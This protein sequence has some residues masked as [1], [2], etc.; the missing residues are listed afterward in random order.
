MRAM[1]VTRH[2]A[3]TVEPVELDIPVP[4][5]SEILVRVSACGVCR[6]D[7]HVVDGELTNATIPIV[8]GHEIVGRVERCGDMVTAFAPGARVGIPWLG[9][10]CGDC[11]FCLG[12]RENLCRRARYTG[13]QI[14]GG[15]AQRSKV[16]SLGIQFSEDVSASL[17]AGDLILQN[18]TAN[19]GVNASSLVVTYDRNTNTA[20]WI[21]PTLTGG[22]L[23]DGNYT[24]QLMADGIT[25]PAGNAVALTAANPQQSG[26]FSFFRYFGDVD[27]DRDVD[28]YDF[29][30]Y[31][32]TSGKKTGESGFNA[33]LDFNGDGAITNADL[34]AYRAHH[35]TALA[36]P[37]AQAQGRVS[38][39]S[40]A[41][42]V[43]VKP[44]DQHGG[45]VIASRTALQKR[46]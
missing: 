38:A 39:N 9:W 29:F 44:N 19:A 43:I 33:A 4:G 16:S 31:Q 21:F 24:A 40:S 6:T 14:N 27:G 18:L 42:L 22:S 41:E 11:E 8:P 20:T 28:F 3:H 26:A 2:G 23:A 7:L 1:A 34:D 30:F 12:G 32:R 17:A 15:E 35:L 36:A 5:P 25:D 46:P 13:Y 45:R 10:S 37:V